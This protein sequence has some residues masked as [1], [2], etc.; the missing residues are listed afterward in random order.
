MKKAL[1]FDIGG[2]KIYSTMKRFNG[3]RYDA[4]SIRPIAITVEAGFETS[5][6]GATGNENYGYADEKWDE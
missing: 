4:P 3:V 1:A 5:I 2:T 6:S